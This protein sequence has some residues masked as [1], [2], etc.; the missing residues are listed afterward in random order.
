MVSFRLNNPAI[1]FQ[2]ILFFSFS[3]SIN[4]FVELKYINLSSYILFHITYIYLSFYYYNYSLFLTGFIYGVFYDLVFINYIGPHLLTFL[5]IL[6]IIITLKKN[7]INLNPNKIPYILIIFL[8]CS[9]LIEMIIASI[10]FN[11]P[12]KFYIYLELILIG[13][14]FFIPSVYLFSKLDKF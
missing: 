13:L 9:I 7:L 1:Y 4:Y 2:L 12:F 11:Y 6:L 3:V 8:F 5:F 14:I 10:I